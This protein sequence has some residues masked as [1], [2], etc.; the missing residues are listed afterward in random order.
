MVYNHSDELAGAV[1][2]SRRVL[3]NGFISSPSPGGVR[4]RGP[5][6]AVSSTGSGR[7]PRTRSV[8]MLWLRV[9]IHMNVRVIYYYTYI[10]YKR[11]IGVY[12]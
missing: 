3:G 6:H 8:Y 7:A 2:S 4:G 5:I 10:A 1:P 9:F 11:R 12:L